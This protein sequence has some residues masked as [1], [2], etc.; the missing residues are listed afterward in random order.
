MDLRGFTVEQVLVKKPPHIEQEYYLGIT[1]DR[2][3]QANVVIFSTEG[4]VDIEEIA[5]KTPEKVAKLWL[6]AGLGLRDF[7]IRDWPSGRRVDRTC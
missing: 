7:H 1:V 4:G 3:R 5:E 2:D 6:D